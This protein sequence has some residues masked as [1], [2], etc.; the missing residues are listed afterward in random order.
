MGVVD[1]LL[2]TI[3]AAVIVLAVRLMIKRKRRG[4]CSGDCGRCSGCH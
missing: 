2:I 3:I 1:F 4:G